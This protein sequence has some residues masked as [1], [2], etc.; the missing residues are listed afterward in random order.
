MKNN[1]SSISQNIAFTATFAALCCV[2]TFISVPLPIGYFNL[3]DIF[4]LISA[5]CL[6]PVFGAIAASVGT[7]LADIL[8]SYVLY[9]P[10]TLIIKGG[11]AVVAALLYKAL[12]RIM[13]GNKSDI[14]SR[15]IAAV[16]GEC[17]M[18]GGYFLYEAIFL[19]YGLGA[20][21]SLPGNGLQAVAAVI[22]ATLLITALF[23][24][25]AVRNIFKN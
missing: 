19:R 5:W 15:V 2:A 24:S 9:A 6:G 14:L 4:V 23:S 21:A 22:G 20:V 11:M 12:G 18:V 3:G 7:A 17:V 16:S 25:R 13:K 8:M 10:A 1:K